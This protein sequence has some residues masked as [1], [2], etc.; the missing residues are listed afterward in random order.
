MNAFR[1]DFRRAQLVCRFRNAPEKTHVIDRV[2][3]YTDNASKLKF[4]PKQTFTEARMYKITYGVEEDTDKELHR[5]NMRELKAFLES[6]YPALA[7]KAAGRD[8]ACV[9]LT[10]AYISSND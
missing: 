6:R 2:R 1:K 8:N 9:D 3:S 5:A 7:F 4:I 10:R